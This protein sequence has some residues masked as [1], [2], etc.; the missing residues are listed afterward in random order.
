M[1]TTNDLAGLSWAGLMAFLFRDYGEGAFKVFLR[2]VNEDRRYGDLLTVERQ[3]EIGTFKELEEMGL[4]AVAET[5]HKTLPHLWQVLC[6]YQD[7][8]RDKIKDDWKAEAEA[9]RKAF[10]AKNTPRTDVG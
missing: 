7:I 10:M 3:Q 8:T 9:A 6:P 1:T 4:S 5:M 2:E